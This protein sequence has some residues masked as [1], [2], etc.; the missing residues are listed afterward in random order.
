MKNET[1]IWIIL[2]TVIVMVIVLAYMGGKNKKE[3]AKLKAIHSA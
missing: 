3:I 2:T 1:A